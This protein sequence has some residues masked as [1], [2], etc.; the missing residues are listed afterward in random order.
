LKALISV[1]NKTGVVEFAKTLHEIGY[2]LVSTGGTFKTLKHE[3]NLPVTEVSD[4]T[5]SPEIMDG[6]V[7]T[8]HPSV[9]GG[10]L[11]RRDVPKH[12]EELAALGIEKIDLV[13]VNLYPFID[14]IR[15]PTITLEEALEN[16]DIGGPTMIRAAAKNFQFVT[17]I[18][19]P[20][21]YSWVSQDLKLSNLT[22]DKRRQL[23]EKAFRHVS[24]YD[25]TIAKYLE[26]KVTAFPQELTIAYNKLYDL[27]YGENPHQ[28]A[29]FYAN[30]INAGGLA[31]AKQLNGKPLSFNNILDADAAWQTVTDFDQPCVAVIKHTTPC[32]LSVNEDL[33]EAYNRAFEGDTISAFGGIVAINRTVTT[34]VAKALNN[35][36]YEI[37]LATDYEEQAITILSQKKNLRIL[38]V[39]SNSIIED[40]W[41]LKKVSS[42]ILVQTVDHI[43][44]DSSSWNIATKRVPTSMEMMDLQ[45]AWKAVKHVKSNAIVLAKNLSLIGVGAGQPNR[46]TSVDLALNK[47]GNKRHGSVLASDAFFPFPDSIERAGKSGITAIIQPGGS[48]RD[49]ES[50]DMA[51]QHNIAMILTGER[52]FRH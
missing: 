10:I 34:E 19:D 28:Q 17:V 41:D 46:V 37:V 43:A 52:H 13:V 31:T 2:S 45:F 6:R 1:Y 32:G 22:Q 47:A 38:Q 20:N 14:K 30:V 26:T 51:N 16:I 7:K 25:A 33:L 21:D 3:G 5:G 42:G 24:L 11:A 12:M 9:H 44:K 8:L 23:A 4:L 39:P 49:Q 35:I 48:I 36:F 29:A 15:D 40:D 27:R 18:V 50:I